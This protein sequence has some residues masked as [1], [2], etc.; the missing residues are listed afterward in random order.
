VGSFTE[1]LIFDGRATGLSPSLGP[2]HQ[3]G[4]NIAQQ[5]SGPQTIGGTLPPTTGFQGQL[6]C[7]RPGQVRRQDGLNTPAEN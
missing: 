5:S 7:D 3:T 6:R 1:F 2:I 4:Q